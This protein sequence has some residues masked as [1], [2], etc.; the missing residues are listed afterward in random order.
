M[1]LKEIFILSVVFLS[2][3][4]ISCDDPEVMGVPDYMTELYS[5]NEK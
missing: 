1:A 5:T 2:L 4:L 3:S